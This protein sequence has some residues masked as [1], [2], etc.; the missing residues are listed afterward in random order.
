MSCFL[1]LLS[2]QI[3]WTLLTHRLSS[4]VGRRRAH[5]HLAGGKPQT[6]QHLFM[7]GQTEKVRCWEW[8]I[9]SQR[10]AFRAGSQREQSMIRRQT[11]SSREAVT[12]RPE[13]KA[14]PRT[15]LLFWS[16][17]PLWWQR[18][19]LSRELLMAALSESLLGSSRWRQK[20][21]VSGLFPGPLHPSTGTLF[22]SPR[23]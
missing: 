15:H 8:W 19:H 13:C 9:R 21:P 18:P 1:C 17:C 16:S 5:W 3:Q 4:A 11:R 6:D 14:S 20:G 22:S 23:G 2:A 7:D 10:S 12:L